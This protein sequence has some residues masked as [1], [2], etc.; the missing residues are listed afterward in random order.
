M[1][2]ICDLVILKKTSRGSWPR[3]I[4]C[5]VAGDSWLFLEKDRQKNFCQVVEFYSYSI[6]FFV[7]VALVVVYTVNRCLKLLVFGFLFL[8]IYIGGSY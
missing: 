2:I 3:F 6:S 8:C 7:F 4:F 5:T 1:C